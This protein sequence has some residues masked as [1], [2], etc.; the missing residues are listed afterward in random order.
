MEFFLL[1]FCWNREGEGD[2]EVRERHQIQKIGPKRME[3]WKI[4][5]LGH[6]NHKYPESEWVSDSVLPGEMAYTSACLPVSLLYRCDELLI[7]VQWMMGTR[8]SSFISCVQ[9]QQLFS[10]LVC[11]VVWWLAGDPVVD[12]ILYSSVIYSTCNG[13]VDVVL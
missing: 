3:R 1:L 11:L 2:Q 12:F 6:Y 7:P 8:S 13:A 4:P 9:Q 5:V 10:S